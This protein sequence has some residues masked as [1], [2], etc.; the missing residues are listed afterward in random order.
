M[1]TKS[2][3]KVQTLS[4]YQRLMDR[5]EKNSDQYLLPDC[6]LVLR[7]DG[8]RIG[9]LW[10][11]INE[12]PYNEK[13]E[14][15]LL[16][17]ARA[18]MIAGSKVLFSFHHGDEITFVLDKS[19]T[20]S[21]RTVV[22]VVSTICSTAGSAFQKSAGLTLQ[23]HAKL[24]QLT[25]QLQILDYFFWQRKVVQRNFLT[26]KLAVEL[27]KNGSKDNELLT[28]LTR[29][30]E[31]ERIRLARKEGFPL[32]SF[33]PKYITGTMIW[34]NKDSNDP[35]SKPQMVLQKVLPTDE[36]EF[37]DFLVNRLDGV[38]HNPLQN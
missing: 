11:N 26:H 28:K 8:K 35:K 4:D 17:T 13:I 6:Y 33:E 7:I 3:Y 2:G 5:F 16:D 29:L 10:D 37:V 32:E 34:W 23:F 36:N 30:T 31:E 9:S 38:T 1:L 18:V 22:K 14:N 15:S 20:L 24:L 12:Y 19:E 25:T 27:S 21:P